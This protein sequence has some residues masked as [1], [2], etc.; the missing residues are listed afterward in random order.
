MSLCGV[1]YSVCDLQYEILKCP[2]QSKACQALDLCINMRMPNLVPN[3]AEDY[4]I[5]ILLTYL[6]NHFWSKTKSILRDLT[7]KHQYLEE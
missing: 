4:V 7:R 2:S 6:E 3:S 5:Q 1:Q